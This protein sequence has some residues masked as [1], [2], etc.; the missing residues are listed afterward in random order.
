[1][2][3]NSLGGVIFPSDLKP[4]T[5]ITAPSQAL[6]ALSSVCQGMSNAFVGTIADL[7]GGSTFV[8]PSA[9]KERNMH[10]ALLFI[11]ILMVGNLIAG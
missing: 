6:L 3:T 1:M 10:L 9:K 2:A 4:S 5:S 7:H 8:S 11:I